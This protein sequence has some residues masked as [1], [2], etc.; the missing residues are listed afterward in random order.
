MP[1]RMLTDLDFADDISLLS[2]T[3]EKACRLLCEVE[4]HCNR[5]GLGIN[6][7]KTKVMPINADEPEVRLSTLD[8][9]PLEVDGQRLEIPMSADT[10]RILFVSTVESVLLY[11]SEAW[12]L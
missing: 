11:G 3:A 8:G 6:A 1:A 2:D 5:I 9:K 12:T 4:R 10:K 7:K